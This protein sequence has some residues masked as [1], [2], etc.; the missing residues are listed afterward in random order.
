[1]EY[2]GSLLGDRMFARL[3]ASDGNLLRDQGSKGKRGRGRRRR[4][5]GST[6]T[7][8]ADRSQVNGIGSTET[9]DEGGTVVE[10]GLSENTPLLN[11]SRKSSRTPVPK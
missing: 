2:L 6:W 8:F 7:T 10:D 3:L 11:G 4:F 1:M 5:I 9:D